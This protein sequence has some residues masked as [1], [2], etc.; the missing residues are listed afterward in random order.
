M[1]SE[2]AAFL[3]VEEI[4]SSSSASYETLRSSL[5]E[6]PP[7]DKNQKAFVGDSWS[8]S[9]EEDDEKV[10][11]EICLVAHASSEICLGVDL[12]PNEWIKDSGCSKHMTGN[13]KLLSTYKAYN[14]GNVV[15]GSNLR[16][17]IIG[18][19]TISNDSQNR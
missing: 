2:T 6:E 19:G 8:D 7:K 1:F 11:E 3:E 10:K 17:N 9:G 15:F 5:K 12:E 13:R 16:G 4:T 14:G 18:K